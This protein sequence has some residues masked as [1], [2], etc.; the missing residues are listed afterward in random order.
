MK[1]LEFTHYLCTVEQTL[2]CQHTET[3]VMH[4]I[5][6][7]LEVSVIMLC[8]HYSNMYVVMITSYFYRLYYIYIVV[9]HLYIFTVFSRVYGRHTLLY[10][11]H[12]GT[13]THWRTC[14]IHCNWS[15]LGDFTLKIC[16]YDPLYL[17]HLIFR[18]LS[19]FYTVAY[20]THGWVHAL[21]RFYFACSISCML[22]SVTIILENIFYYI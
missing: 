3:K 7:Q 17:N 1:K 8:I 20:A 5:I 2:L 6:L 13:V 21:L 19:L 15:L 18:T 12:A 14:P 9:V 11:C 4:L 22:I 16:G 10:A